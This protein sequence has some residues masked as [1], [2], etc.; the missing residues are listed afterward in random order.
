MHPC[1]TTYWSQ[2]VEGHSA[3]AGTGS[4]EYQEEMSTTLCLIV[5]AGIL[6]SAIALVVQQESMSEPSLISQTAVLKARD[7]TNSNERS[8]R[9]FP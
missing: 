4:S 5:V 7:P 8:K 6:M 1:L 9:A 2:A 3:L